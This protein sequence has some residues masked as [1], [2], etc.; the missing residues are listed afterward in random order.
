[1]SQTKTESC[2][3]VGLGSLCIRCVE[4][5]LDHS[6]I[7]VRGVISADDS[8]IAF[9]RERK[10]P[11]LHVANKVRYSASKS[12]IDAFLT[13]APFD[14]LFSVINAMFLPEAIIRLPRKMA[15]NFHDSELPKYAG[16]DVTSWA[17]MRQEPHHAV[18]WH[19]MS[20]EIDQGHIVKQK[21]VPLAKDETAYTLNERCLE[22]GFLTFK[23][24]VAELATGSVVLRP[25]PLELKTYYSRS[26]PHLEEMSIWRYGVMS[27]NR[28]GEELEAL[29]R[30]L[31]YGPTRNSLGSA[32]LALGRAF[33]I[34]PTVSLLGERSGLAPGTVVRATG[35]E[36]VVAT[37][38]VDV[39][40]RELLTIEA[41]PISI[42]D[43]IAKHGL[44]PGQ[45]LPETDDDLL[46]K[47]KLLD[48]D[49]MW[50]EAYW[51]SALKDYRVMELPWSAEGSPGR[52][53]VTLS[54]SARAGIT[55]I[56]MSC[57][58]SPSLVLLSCFASL[59][60]E[61]TGVAAPAVWYSD[62][63]Y[64]SDI[65]GMDGLFSRFMLCTLRAAPQHSTRERCL[66]VE[67]VVHEVRAQRHFPLDLAYRHPPLRVK[68]G[69][70][71][72]RQASFSVGAVANEVSAAG[73]AFELGCEVGGD[74][75][76][77]TIVMS[78]AH[79]GEARAVHIAQRLAD[80]V[81]KLCVQSG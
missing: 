36:L 76:R 58:L 13:A 41:C 46:H 77:F 20:A 73:P 16:I 70:A 59:V 23:D 61:L 53:E 81:D 7:E 48:K 19:L 56:A 12:E 26:K 71:H 29:A 4:Y 75:G 38:T 8:V 11:A 27:W 44:A 34:V 55:K 78:C 80:C 62:D 10:V 2:F 6:H 57:D 52:A 28:S 51:V 74:G 1:M 9:A 47:V 30:A 22:E 60:S 31:D 15:V 17:I 69:Y 67:R 49:L 72:T 68:P 35:G 5:L 43:V 21:Q 37:A 64:R 18:T 45:R 24:L 32:K 25:Q 39:A 14:Y 79:G 54:E 63:S 66:E 42:A 50:K 3:V 65:E 40:L 33:Y